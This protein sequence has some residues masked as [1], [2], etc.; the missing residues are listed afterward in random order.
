MYSLL[1]SINSSEDIKKLNNDQLGLLIDEVRRYIIEVVSANGGH[2]ASNLGVVELTVALHKTFNTPEDKI[3]WDVGHQSYAHKILTGRRDEFK[4]LRKLNGISGFPKRDESEFDVFD[5]GHSSTSI[6]SALG[7]A[8]ARDLRGDKHSV[9]AVIGDGALTGGMALEALNHAGDFPTNLI[10][11]L[12]DNNM[13]ISRNIGGMSNY[14]S[15]IRTVPAYFKFKSDVEE[16]LNKVPIIGNPLLK[17]AE[18]LKNWVKYLLVPG[19]L[20]EELGFKYLGPIDGHN[21]SHL[22]DV[23]KRAKSIDGY[24]VLIH[25]ITKKGKGYNYAER[26]PEKYHGV[27]PFDLESGEVITKSNKRNYSNIFGN[28]IVSLAEKNDKILA[29][30]AAMPDGTGLTEFSKRFKD[31]FF[32]VGIAEQ[33]AVTFCAGLA[34]GGYK[35][36][37]AVYSTFLQRAYDQIVHDVCMQNLPVILAVD[38]AGIVGSDGETHHGVFDISYLRHIPNITIMSPKDGRDLEEML[39]LAVKLNSPVAIRYPRGDEPEFDIPHTAVELGRAESLKDGKDGV[40]IAEGRMVA[41]AYDAAKRLKDK[42]LEVAVIN[43]R[44]IKPMDDTTLLA[45]AQKYNKIYTIEDNVLAGGMGSGILEFYNSKDIKTNLKIFS[46]QDKY[47]KQ[48]EIAELQQIEGMDSDN[49][50]NSILKDLTSSK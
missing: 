18:K 48:G 7:I 38:R 5:T 43:M 3:V 33:H 23:L 26:L 32:D 25:V 1:N 15:R 37:F 27:G 30:T 20:F 42:E 6:S 21:I 34:V 39:E 10:V 46:Y 11:V 19:I 2:L 31:R 24:P 14:L 4:T 44:F 13:S 50:Y 40:I 36:I 29:V 12:N 28:H 17:T 35:P 16:L 47:I 9:I 22:E 49:I 41:L 45:L 8:K